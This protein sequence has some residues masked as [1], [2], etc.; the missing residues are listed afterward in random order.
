M[1]KVFFFFF[2][3]H[4]ILN[5]HKLHDFFFVA[6]LFSLTSAFDC[7]V[8]F[9]ALMK[10]KILR[11]LINFAL[12]FLPFHFMSHL[13]L[14]ISAKLLHSSIIVFIKKTFFCKFEKKTKQKT[15]LECYELVKLLRKMTFVYISFKWFLS[16]LLIFS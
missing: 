12:F 3:K 9:R 10:N 7:Q 4:F 6:L 8:F 16:H 11:V 5:A 14:L 1:K 13:I 15:W 2:F